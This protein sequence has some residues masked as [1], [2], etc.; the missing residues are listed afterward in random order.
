MVYLKEMRIKS[1]T[2]Q[3]L[4][5][6]FLVV[7]HLF[8]IWIFTY[9]PTQDGSSHIYNSYVLKEYHKH[10]NYRLREI[11]SLNLL[12]FPNWSSQMIMTAFM[13]IV[14]PIICEK[15]VVSLSIGLLPLAFLYFLYGIDQRRMN[16]GL[17]LVGFIFSYNYLLHMGFYNFSLSLPMFFFSLGF[18]WRHK[19]RLTLPRLG[20]LYLLL[21]LT[22]LS[23]FQSFLQLVV[24]MTCFAIYSHL[25]IVLTDTCPSKDSKINW[26]QVLSGLMP[27]VHF[28][29]FMLPI[30]FIMLAY[31]LSSTV[32]YQQNHWQFTHLLEYFFNMKSMVYYSDKHIIVGQ[33]V[34]VM[35]AIAFLLTVW[36]RIQRVIHRERDQPIWVSVIDGKE[37][38]LLAAGG[39][40]WLFFYVPWS[41]ES[42]GG[43]INDRV[44][45]YIF[46][47]LIPFFTTNMHFYIRH[48]F[49]IV[50]TLLTLYH[51]GL[52]AYA[53]YH[54]DRETSEMTTAVDKIEPHS[55]LTF[56]S[57][58][59]DGP[60]HRTSP[61]IGPIKYTS[62]FLHVPAFY[63]IGNGAVF[64]NNYEAEL[65]YF[66]IN[67][68]TN[69][70]RWIKSA[71]YVLAWR[72]ENHHDQPD[73]ERSYERIHS[74]I[75]YSLYQ[76]RKTDKAID[77]QKQ[78]FD[79]L[80]Y[81]FQPAGAPHQA[82]SITVEP[83]ICYREHG[84]G[85]VTVSNRNGQYNNAT[86]EF[87][88]RDFV[89]DHFDGV[90]KIDLPNGQYQVKVQFASSPTPKPVRLNLI[91]NGKKI[92]SNQILPTQ[93]ELVSHSYTLEITDGQ[94]TQIIYVKQ[95]KR[96]ESKWQ[97]ASCY[98]KRIED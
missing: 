66:P 44:H 81:D 58:L 85:W 91:A 74:G 46:L 67:Y 42:G 72:M 13:H 9:F 11:Y 87:P 31:Y 22:Y 17:G 48:T 12:L 30:Y 68:K 55:T 95:E 65:P 98:I 1:V 21:L 61:Y 29:G 37:Q 35:L 76:R 6:V 75:A 59:W 26:K 70:D 18:W 97:W 53:Y 4:L 80:L 16:F 82:N 78:S 83:N 92:I 69:P 10:T 40:T 28:V 96:F 20:I 38:F 19:T 47:V 7:L 54:L 36:D 3:V 88:N 94:L 86:E 14:P 41:V 71:D 62:P 57:S 23:H 90:F 50:I 8:P 24:I 2:P 39:L 84:Y 56:R 43:W 27:L 93:N 33:L 34:L 77:W 32:G 73:L 15:I 52:T 25:Y 64:L 79:Q 49:T 89:T 5:L 63:C 45:I 51:F 60:A